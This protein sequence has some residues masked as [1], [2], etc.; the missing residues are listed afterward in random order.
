M[1][2]VAVS[3]L[4]WSAQSARAAEKERERASTQRVRRPSWTLS[5]ERRRTRRVCILEREDH[6][7]AGVSA[8]WSEISGFHYQQS[9]VA[10]ILFCFG[11]YDGIST[12][13]EVVLCVPSSF[14]LITSRL[15]A[16]ISSPCPLRTTLSGCIIGPK[17]KA[18]RAS[19]AV[20]QRLGP[21]RAS[22]SNQ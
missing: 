13:C 19:V 18:P 20:E 6:F 21:S 8:S 3:P 2:T 10:H 7:V 14:S 1:W 9:S 5:M 17:V 16:V 4:S 12:G 11:I 15:S 22:L